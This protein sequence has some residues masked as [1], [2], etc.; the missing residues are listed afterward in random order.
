MAIKYNTKT[1]DKLLNIKAAQLRDLTLKPR[2]IGMACS[3]CDEDSEFTFEQH[4]AYPGS[5]SI[6]WDFHAC[7]YDFE[8]KV[9]KKLGIYRDSKYS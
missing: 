5:G 9:Y 6:D 4:K 1:G 2:L 8:Q 3:K 7:C